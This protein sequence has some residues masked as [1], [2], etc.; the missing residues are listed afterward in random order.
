MGNV[1]GRHL[2]HHRVTH[3]FCKR[4]GFIGIFCQLRLH[5][6]NTIGCQQA[7]GDLLRQKFSRGLSFQQFCRRLFLHVIKG[8]G[9]LFWHSPP[10]GIP[11]QCAHRR[12]RPLWESVFHHLG[13]AGKCY[14]FLNKL[15]AHQG[16]NHRLI[17]HLDDWQNRLGHRSCR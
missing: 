11:G 9:F 16:Q 8:Q 13:G 12:G 6:W 4:H 14:P 10:V 7:I 17:R 3:F 15:I 5:G 2:Q 1:R